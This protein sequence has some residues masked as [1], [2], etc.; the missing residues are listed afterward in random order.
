M[1]QAQQHINYAETLD[2]RT[3]QFIIVG[4]LLGLFLS[5]LDQTIV[6]TALPRITQELNGLPLYSW[7]T[8]AYLLTSC[9]MVPIYGKLSDL[10]GRKP[11][12]LVGIAVFLLGSALCGLS[13]EPFLGGLFGGGMMQLVVFRGVQG[14]GAAAL[15]T[16]A[17]AIVADIFEPRDRAKYQGLF[18]AVF[19]LSSVVG[20]LLGG[21]LTD[22]LSWRWVFYV[23]LPLGLIAIAFITAKM[24]RLASGLKAIIDYVGAALIVIFTV[25]LLLALT[26]GA[27][28]NYAWTS[29]TVLG[30][31]ALSAAAL[32]AFIFWEARHPSPIVSLSLFKLPTF[33]WVMI[34]RFLMGAGFLGAV[35]FTTLY[36]VNV[37]GFSATGAGTAT[38]PLTFGFILGAQSSGLIASRIGRYKKLLVG[39]F[40][41]ATLAF[42]WLST[43]NADTSYPLLAARMVLVGVGLGPSVALFNLAVQNAV[44]PYQIGVATSAGTFFQQLGSTIGVAIFGTVLTSTLSTQFKQNFAEVARTAPPQL[45]A[46]IAKFQQGTASGG[47]GGQGFDLEAVKRQAEQGIRQSFAQQYAG[48]EQAI[49][50]GDPA[51]FAA[52]KNSPQVPAPLR[53]GLANIP[54]QAV[55][56]PQGQ[57]QILTRLRT[58][59]DTAQAQALQQTDTTLDKVG[60]AVKVS[61]ANSIA[62][63]YRFGIF[64]ILLALLAVLFLPDRRLELRRPGSGVTPAAVD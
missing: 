56:S 25:P 19:G 60:R 48:I 29:A 36:L 13:G 40:A 15:A 57:T 23:N 44:Q 21:F 2:L 8:T 28:G 42:W 10:Y 37:K 20:P 16:V 51:Q 7:V 43:I 55:Q 30:L 39:A 61:F 4:V 45:Q 26:W 18:G 24:P 31:F 50:S 58:G 3:K 27:D 52:L 47:Q 5:A 54:N 32:V 38:I 17:F 53:T 1:T 22:G 11:I 34:A 49:R 46:Q 63:I 12:L 59:L 41:L 64:V 33:T 6:S 14:I 35:L 62:R 9:A